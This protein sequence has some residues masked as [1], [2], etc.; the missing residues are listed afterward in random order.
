VSD[1]DDVARAVH[2]ALARPGIF[3]NTASDLGLLELTLDAA[4]RFAG[5]PARSEI[6]EAWARAG[7]EPLF[8]P[9]MDDV[10]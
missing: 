5:A 1:P 8:V 9:G 2:W 6:D 3:V 7:V 4:E 10:R